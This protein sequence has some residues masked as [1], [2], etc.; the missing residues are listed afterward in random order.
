MP[1][2]L[3]VLTCA[4]AVTPALADVPPGPPPPIPKIPP[5][6]TE[7]MPVPIEAVVAGA[8]WAAAMVAG[9]VWLVR[10]GRPR[11]TPGGPT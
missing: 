8:A 6:S 9:G 11:A 5:P 2:L 1:R 7:P 3:A 4:V 10:R